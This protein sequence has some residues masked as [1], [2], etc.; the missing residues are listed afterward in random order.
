MGKTKFVGVHQFWSMQIYW[1]GYLLTRPPKSTFS[2][3]MSALLWWFRRNNASKLKGYQFFSIWISS[4]ASN[5]GA[6]AHTMVAVLPVNRKPDER[7]R[8]HPGLTRWP[9]IFPGV[10]AGTRMAAGYELPHPYCSNNATTTLLPNPGATTIILG[11]DAIST[12][13]VRVQTPPS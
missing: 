5:H 1:H 3:H 6:V 4:G 11:T 10:P 7:F 2:N 13:S 9:A 8:T 12:K